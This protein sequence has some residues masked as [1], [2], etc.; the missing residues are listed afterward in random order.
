MTGFSETLVAY[1]WVAISEEEYTRIHEKTGGMNGLGQDTM[2]IKNS[3]LTFQPSADYAI[4]DAKRMTQKAT[5]V[6]K[7]GFDE[8][9]C[10]NALQCALHGDTMDFPVTVVETLNFA[11][12]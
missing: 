4:E 3:M 12:K 7:L 2:I 8:I 5:L 10:I 11:K 6:C 1:A 9:A